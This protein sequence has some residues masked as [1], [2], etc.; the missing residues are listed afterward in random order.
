MIKVSRRSNGVALPMGNFDRGREILEAIKESKGITRDEIHDT[1]GLGKSVI[2]NNVTILKDLDLVVALGYRKRQLNITDRGI[3]LLSLLQD[4]SNRGKLKEFSDSIIIHSK[5]LLFTYMLIKN[6]GRIEYNELGHLIA[7]EFTIKWENELTYTLVGRSAVSYLVGIGLI[8]EYD[9][10]RKRKPTGFRPMVTAT[11]IIKT[12]K[13]YS[14]NNPQPI[15]TN[16][17]NRNLKSRRKT[18]ATMLVELGLIRNVGGANHKLTPMG[19][20]LKNVI[21]KPDE[22]KV[23]REVILMNS[24]VQNILKILRDKYEKIGWMEISNVLERYNEAKWGVNTQKWFGT[25]FLSWLKLAGIAEPNHE[26]GKF[27]L[28][29][30]K[31][32][33]IQSKIPEIHEV[34]K[35]PALETSK[36]TVVSQNGSIINHLGELETQLVN[37]F[38]NIKNWHSDSELKQNILDILSKLIE[39]DN[40][41]ISIIAEYI[42]SDIEEAFENHD[43]NIISKVTG[44]NKRLMEDIGEVPVVP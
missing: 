10:G 5:S 19:K 34:V 16:L 23:F 32:E 11:I 15:Y 21:N 41:Q 30:S 39:S 35:K 44:K 20:K 1:K 29:E 13:K 38:I 25:K 24:H 40:S 4:E 33:A 22:G 7:K 42:K 17:D 36:K 12:V 31:I 28:S 3:M 6:R 27:V 8:E 2:S 26:Y 9:V 14:M 37:I 18:E 43:I